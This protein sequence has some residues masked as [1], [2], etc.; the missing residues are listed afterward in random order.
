MAL[1]ML[2][3]RSFK[4]VR[5]VRIPDDREFPDVIRD[6]DKYYAFK[7]ADDGIFDFYETT[8]F[9]IRGKNGKKRIAG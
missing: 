7:L 1:C 5:S 2:L 3:D 6:G 4:L 9:I 8:P